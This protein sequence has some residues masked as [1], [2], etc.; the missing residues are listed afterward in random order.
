MADKKKP[1][2]KK[3]FKPPFNSSKYPSIKDDNIDDD[4]AKSLFSLIT[5]GNI[6]EIEKFLLNNTVSINS[7]HN[8]KNALHVLIESS[9][10]SF[11]KEAIADLLIKKGIKAWQQRRKVKM[12]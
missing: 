11:D 5:G 7:L 6:N 2:F 1:Y 12:K 4:K 8:G 3:T 9:L 10:D